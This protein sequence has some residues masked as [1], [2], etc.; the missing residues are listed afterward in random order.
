MNLIQKGVSSLMYVVA[1]ICIALS[2]G[3]TAQMIY[4][5]TFPF[6]NVTGALTDRK[7]VV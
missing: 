6:W 5:N 2:M 3:V 4:G 1:G 7:S